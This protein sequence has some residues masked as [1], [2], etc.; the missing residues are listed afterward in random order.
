MDIYLESFNDSTFPDYFTVYLEDNGADSPLPLDLRE[1]VARYAIDPAH[2]VVRGIRNMGSG[3][4][5]GY[6]E[7][8]NIDDPVWE[9]GI[10]ILEKHRFK[11]VG[12]AALPAFLDELAS[13]GRH[14]FTA[15]ILP[16]NL[17]SRALFEGVGSR[18][19]G[20]E[21][22]RSGTEKAYGDKLG[23]IGEEK[24]KQLEQLEEL[25]LGSREEACVYE[26]EWPPRDERLPS[27]DGV[28]Q[29]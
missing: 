19:L 26:L 16:D 4:I 27:N 1:Q 10:Y 24:F 2:A 5:L 12:K 23:E 21:T 11:G 22:P 9:I 6:C 29:A 15:R 25:V 3:E 8:Q 17:P 14:R 13:M 18:L 28:F 20:M 7:V